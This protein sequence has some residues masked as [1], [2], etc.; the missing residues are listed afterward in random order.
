MSPYAH[1]HTC[2]HVHAHTHACK[3]TQHI[4]T[5]IHMHMHMHTHIHTYART[6]THTCTHTHTHMHTRICTHKN[7]TYT[8]TH[9]HMLCEICLFLLSLITL[10]QTV[11][12]FYVSLHVFSGS[13]TAVHHAFLFFNVKAWPQSQTDLFTCTMVLHCGHTF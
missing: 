5:C 4:Y 1:T 10:P 9:A 12:L 3:H 8:C 11:R 13:P 6:H 7:S 2:M